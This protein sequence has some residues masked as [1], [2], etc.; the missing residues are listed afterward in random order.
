MKYFYLKLL[1][2]SISFLISPM[3]SK[4]V[5]IPIFSIL[6]SD[7]I[8]S[9]FSF[10]TDISLLHSYSAVFNLLIQLCCYSI[11]LLH[12]SNL[13]YSSSYYLTRSIDFASDS[14][15][16]FRCSISCFLFLCKL[17]SKFLLYSIIYF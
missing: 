14:L 9:I 1:A 15:F 11:F 8:A 4:A 13:I 2:I 6:I 17:D 12:S 10:S 7:L 5:E 16:F 3:L